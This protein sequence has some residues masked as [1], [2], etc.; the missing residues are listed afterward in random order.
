MKPVKT[1]GL[2]K[3]SNCGQFFGELNAPA[4]IALCVKNVEIRFSHSQVG[5]LVEAK[6]DSGDWQVVQLTKHGSHSSHA[7]GWGM[8]PPYWIRRK[9]KKP[10]FPHLTRKVLT[11]K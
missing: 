4:H 3:C 6:I 8:F 11:T 5:M 10:I 7:Y 2:V 9:M 1:P